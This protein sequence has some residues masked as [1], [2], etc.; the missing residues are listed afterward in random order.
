MY[1]RFALLQYTLSPETIR[2]LKEPTFN[3]W[4]WEPNEV[5]NN[6]H[7]PYPPRVDIMT[8]VCLLRLICMT[9][10]LWHELPISMNFIGFSKELRGAL[11]NIVQRIMELKLRWTVC[12]FL[13]M[14]CLFEQ[15]YEELG[16]VEEFNINPNVLRRFLVCTLALPMKLS[17]LLVFVFPFGSR[18]VPLPTK[19]LLRDCSMWKESSSLVVR[20]LLKTIH[21]EFIP[22]SLALQWRIT[23]PTY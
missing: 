10:A 7:V 22:N 21:F 18:P 4:H 11:V 6:I 12:C 13:Q 1:L 20:S 17:C 15:M 14:I 5:S 19:D 8:D 9:M 16:L 2:Y 3:I 23:T